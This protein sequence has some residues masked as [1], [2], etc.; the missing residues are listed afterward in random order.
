MIQSGDAKQCIQFLEQLANSSEEWK[1]IKIMLLG[2]GNAGKTTFL[3]FLTGT[4]FDIK[5][6][7]PTFGIDIDEF[8]FNIDG[9]ETTMWD[10]AGQLHYPVPFI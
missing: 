10:F 1:R 2:D 9:I 7:K 6:R 8:S 5:Q 4:P 3:K